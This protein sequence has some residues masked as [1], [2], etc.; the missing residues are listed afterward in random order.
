MKLCRKNTYKS[1]KIAYKA[2]FKRLKE[3]QGL[4]VYWCAR[5]HGWHLTK[6]RSI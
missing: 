4:R 6:R 5:C 2:L 3:V 1:M